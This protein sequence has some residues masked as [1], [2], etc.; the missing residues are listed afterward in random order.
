[1]SSTNRRKML[2]MLAIAAVVPA[3]IARTALAATPGSLIAPPPGSMR[4][5]RV[6]VRQLA[7]GATISV[8][9]D[10]EIGFQRFTDGFIIEGRQLSA[11]VTAPAN[12]AAFADLERARVETAMF[13]I[14][15]D[16]FGQI[17]SEVPL[18]DRPQQIDQ[19]YSEALLQIAR[20]PLAEGER[21]ELRQFV[22]ALHL[23]GTMLAAVMPPDL[24]SPA[25]GERSD[26]RALQLPTGDMGRV[27]SRF[28]AERDAQTGLMRRA[29]REV[30]TEIDGDRRNTTEH[31]QLDKS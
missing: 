15:L 11:E 10:F 28:N 17:L 13:P 1:M 9:R 26:D 23:A 27:V 22:S 5:Q 14:T 12:L 3:L 24:F 20:Q 30:L 16:P 6:A 25:Q 4:F 21:G 8:T 18:V 31:W 2:K 29:M 19:A 7:G